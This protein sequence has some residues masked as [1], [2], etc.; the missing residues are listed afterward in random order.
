VTSIG[1]EAVQSLPEVTSQLAQATVEPPQSAFTV[2]LPTPQAGLPKISSD[3]KGVPEAVLAPEQLQ[4]SIPETNALPLANQPVKPPG[5]REQMVVKQPADTEL[6]TV[7][8][9]QAQ[10]LLNQQSQDDNDSL[11]RD[12]FPANHGLSELRTDK[13]QE[14]VFD[15][16]QQIS[17]PNQQ[18]IVRQIVDHARLY[19]RPANQSEMVLQ[20]RPEHLG[21]LTLK[22]SVESGIV[23]ATFHSDNPEVRQVIEA[24]L[25]QLK[26]DLSQQGIKLDSVSV[27][28]GSEQF[29]DN[30][31]PSA[32]QQQSV[33]L[34]KNRRELMQAIEAAEEV[35]VST[36][37]GVDYRI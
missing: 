13:L 5:G 7:A 27:F 32:Q 30:R 35:S 37:D 11:S 6:S 4:F 29:F 2:Q 20:L 3:E 9:L 21:E 12:S 24:S 1:Q 26:Q 19:L 25:P 18:E 15:T 34:R 8:P 28:S 14:P 17:T 36:R 33:P 22:V 16:T 31:Q 10:S 23:S